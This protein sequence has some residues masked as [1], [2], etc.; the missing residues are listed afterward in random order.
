M[1]GILE[2]DLHEEREEFEQAV[3]GRKWAH[4]CWEMD[5]WLRKNTKYA[6]DSQPKEVY[7]AF[8]EAR[9]ELYRLVSKNGLDLG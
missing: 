5:Q 7:D 9:D 2:F 3:N 1:K 6:P 4:V 8:Q